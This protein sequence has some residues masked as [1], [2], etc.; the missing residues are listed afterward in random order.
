MT[1][2]QKIRSIASY[3]ASMTRKL[4][5]LPAG[6]LK[7]RKA[8]EKEYAEKIANVKNETN[9][10][11]VKCTCNKVSSKEK[12]RTYEIF[13]RACNGRFIYLGKTTKNPFK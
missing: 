2:I 6:D 8:I 9:I 7:S 10:K 4:A 11:S 3:K 13:E 1:E 12:V 5:K